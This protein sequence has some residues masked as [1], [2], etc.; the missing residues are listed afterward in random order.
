MKALYGYVRELYFSDDN[1]TIYV[2]NLFTRYADGEDEPRIII[3]ELCDEL[4]EFLMI[5][6]RLM[7]KQFDGYTNLELSIIS[8]HELM[9][10]YDE[11]LEAKGK[12][13]NFCLQLDRLIVRCESLAEFGGL[14]SDSLYFEFTIKCS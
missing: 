1:C 13:D 3:G 2:P 11:E 6:S 8:L 14:D 4:Y 5:Q 7:E 12:P 9:N 10:K